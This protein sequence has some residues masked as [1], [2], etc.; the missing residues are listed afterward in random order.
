MEWVYGKVQDEIKRVWRDSLEMN[1][2]IILILLVLV[3]GCVPV[4]LPPCESEVVEKCYRVEPTGGLSL[5]YTID[6]QTRCSEPYDFMIRKSKDWTNCEP[7]YE[8]V[9]K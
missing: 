3:I 1:K 7:I 6:I 5:R 9:Y 8:K 4:D 2:A